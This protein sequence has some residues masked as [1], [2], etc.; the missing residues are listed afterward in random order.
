MI[1]LIWY[2]E[3]PNESASFFFCYASYALCL[4][5]GRDMLDVVKIFSFSST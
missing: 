5:H 2:F 3:F 4:P 1:I